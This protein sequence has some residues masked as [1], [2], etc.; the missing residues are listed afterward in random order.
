MILL[1]LNLLNPKEINYQS[2]SLPVKLLLFFFIKTVKYP[3]FYH[4]EMLGFKSLKVNN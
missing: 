3:S 1:Y 4:K 2:L